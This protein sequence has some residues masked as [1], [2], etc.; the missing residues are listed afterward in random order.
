MTVLDA[1]TLPDDTTSHAALASQNL[2]YGRVATD[3]RAA[4]VAWLQADARGFHQPRSTEAQLTESVEHL[5]ERRTTG[6][7]DATIADASTP[8]AT[9]SSW[10]SSL[11]VS[12]ER[13]IPAWAISSVTVA[14]THRRRGIARALLEGEL[15]T[16]A[17]AGLPLAMLTVT[18]AT[19][20]GRY[21]FAPAARVT[22]LD[23]DRR[24]VSWRGPRPAGRVQFADPAT[25]AAEASAVSERAALR[26]PGAVTRPESHVRHLLGLHDPE[27]ESSRQARVVRYDDEHGE[28]QGFAVYRVVRTPPSPGRVEFDELVAATDDAEAALWRFLLEQDFVG[29][30]RAGLRASDERVPWMLDDPR[31]VATS[32]ASDHLWLRILDVQAALESRRYAAAGRVVIDVDDALGLASGRYELVTDD[33]GDARVETIDAA[34]EDAPAGDI[35]LGVGELSALLLGDVR[36]S[37]LAAAGRLAEET[38]GVAATLDRLFAPERAPHLGFWF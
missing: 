28:L 27:S 38:P 2:D 14:P 12:P 30:I 7:W 17:A 10:V 29:S 37:A 31:A 33:A 34:R 16:A 25:F 36:W 15:R 6:V 13:R 8:V 19:I 24:R 20:Y 35:R 32:S 4:F 18:E 22:T 23:I 1:S 3:D 26:T 5:A 9:V 11:T 21:G